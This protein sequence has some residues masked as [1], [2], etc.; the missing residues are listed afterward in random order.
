M[1]FAVLALLPALASAGPDDTPRPRRVSKVR[2]LR[3]APPVIT[4]QQTTTT[5]T[6]KTQEEI[7]QPL[8]QREESTNYRFAYRALTSLGLAGSEADDKPIGYQ[9]IYGPTQTMVYR[10]PGPPPPRRFSRFTEP[11]DEKPAASPAPEAKPEPAP[12]PG[13]DAAP[14]SSNSPAP[15]PLPVASPADPSEAGV[16][17]DPAEQAAQSRNDEILS[18]FQRPRSARTAR[19]PYPNPGNGNGYNPAQ[20]GFDPSYL[21]PPPEQ[22]PLPPSRATYRVVP[23]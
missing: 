16:L 17:P 6:V 7:I 13:P 2:T 14:V 23:K 20:N 3:S 15:A 1:V 19:S 21:Q 10:R 8:R 22:L 18:Y 9:Q 11:V 4:E 12:P 5:T